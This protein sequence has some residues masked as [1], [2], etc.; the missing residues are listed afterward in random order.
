MVINN[1]RIENL[2]SKLPETSQM[3]EWFRA[4]QPKYPLSVYV[5]SQ[6]QAYIKEQFENVD[7][8]LLD[9]T[10]RRHAVIDM[11]KPY[12]LTYLASGTNRMAFTCDYDPDVVIK[13]AYMPGGKINGD[14]E[15]FAQDKIAPLVSKTFEVGLDG[16]ISLHERVFPL[17]SKDQLYEFRDH[18]L[19]LLLTLYERGYIFDDVGTNTFRNL[20]IR[21]GFGLVILDYATLYSFR[22]GDMRC[23]CGGKIFYDAGFNCMKCY[24]CAQA[25]KSEQIGRASVRTYKELAERYN[26]NELA[27]VDDD[28]IGGESMEFSLVFKNAA[29]E[30][31]EERDYD[32]KKVDKSA[33]LVVKDNVILNPIPEKPHDWTSDIQV[34]LSFREGHK[35][36]IERN[37]K[38]GTRKEG[39]TKKKKQRYETITESSA[40]KLGFGIIKDDDYEE[41]V[42]NVEDI[43]VTDEAEDNSTKELQEILDFVDQ[44]AEEFGDEEAA[45][46]SEEFDNE[47]AVEDTSEDKAKEP[48][49]DYSALESFFGSE[50]ANEILNVTK[51]ETPMI[52]SLEEPELP[53]VKPQPRRRNTKPSKSGKKSKSKSGKKSNDYY[54]NEED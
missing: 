42:P 45:Q 5:P 37:P 26:R 23:R 50:V 54:E 3:Q 17:A 20:G 31:V 43:S 29:G 35:V 27:K 14:A 25:Y 15:L 51:E 36:P 30:V 11:L 21:P 52:S 40:K 1:Q 47:E 7:F 32:T 53:P 22:P 44:L 8:L 38:V 41:E 13:V 18:H 24:T 49:M 46:I 19:L 39:P 4:L 2:E 48:E 33:K 12:G 34:G 10:K 16:L 9:Q 28:Y 6:L